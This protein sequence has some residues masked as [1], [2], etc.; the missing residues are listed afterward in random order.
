MV[1]FVLGIFSSNIIAFFLGTTGMTLL[2]SFRNFT[3]MSKSIATLGVSNSLVKLVVE[4]KEDEKELS[5]IYSTFFWLFLVISV[6]VGIV[7]LIFSSSISELLFFSTDY[8][9]P[10]Q[11]FSLTLPFIVINTFWISIYNAFERFKTIILIQVISNVLVFI[12]TALLIWKQNIVG[13]LLAIAIS[14]II[15]VLVT[16]IFIK[17][18]KGFFNFEVKRVLNNKHLK[19]IRKFSSMALLSAIIIPI[20]LI[21]IRNLLIQ[22]YTF[23]E[24]GIWDAVIRLSG[25]YMLLLSSGLTLYY[26]PKLASLSTDEEFKSELKEYFKTLVPIFILMIVLIYLFKNLIINIAFTP[27]F[28]KVSEILI[29]QLLGDFFRI[30]SLAFGYQILVKTMM[31]KFFFIE[32][33]YNLSYFILSYYLMQNFASEGV[34]MAYF[35]ANVLMF[36]VFLIMFRK[37]LFK[38]KV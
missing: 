20:T 2:G 27:E 29:W 32:I 17:R 24:A 25:F 36:F 5:L 3:T 13:G 7:I 6:V 8:K 38:Q 33:V 28:N 19:E 23:Q 12:V 21:S 31:F 22:S 30:M 10:I 15:M 16:F 9:I 35:F 34:V 4:N 37:V 18:E 26:M 14:E 11:F 1:S